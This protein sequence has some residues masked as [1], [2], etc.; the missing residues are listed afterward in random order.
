MSLIFVKVTTGNHTAYH[1]HMSGLV[2]L[3]AMKGGLDTLGL[4]GFLKQMVYWRVIA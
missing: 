2:S 3:I 1:A 4:N